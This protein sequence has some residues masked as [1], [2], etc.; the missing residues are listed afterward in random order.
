[1]T[2][3]KVFLGIGSN[4]DRDK[5]I[6]KSINLL[7]E[8]FG[9]L[10]ISPV[11]ESEAVGF[12]GNNFYNL[13]VSFTTLLSLDQVIDIYKDIEDQCGR[14]RTGPKFSAR[15]LDIDPLLYDDLI[16]DQPVQLPRDEILANAYVLWPLS[17]IA[18]DQLHPITR[19]S[20]AE[21]WK[22][23]DKKQKLWQVEMSF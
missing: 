7:R 14:E 8:A 11:F 12:S 9:Q 13:V 17:I 6:I 3:T 19:R 10:D 15:K 21:H 16:C 22:N 20:F 5:A 23:Y 4:I 18:P 1:M 2:A